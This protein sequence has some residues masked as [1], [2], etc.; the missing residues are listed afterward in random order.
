MAIGDVYIKFKNV[1]S[2]RKELCCLAINLFNC[3]EEYR[4]RIEEDALRIPKGFYLLQRI[5]PKPEIPEGKL[6]GYHF[7]IEDGVMKRYYLVCD[8][9]D[10]Q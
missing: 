8:G 10:D 5:Y 4:I 7:K 9:A 1:S 6:K 2:T 3:I